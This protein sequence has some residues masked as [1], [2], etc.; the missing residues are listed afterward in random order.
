MNI[1]PL[2]ICASASAYVRNESDIDDCV[3]QI[4]PGELFC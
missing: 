1:S 2:I 4:K 3:G